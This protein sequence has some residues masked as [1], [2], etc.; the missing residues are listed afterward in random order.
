MMAILRIVWV[1]GGISFLVQAPALGQGQMV[2]S[3][4]AANCHSMRHLPFYQQ[5]CLRR[6]IHSRRDKESDNDR[7]VSQVPISGTW[8]SS[9]LTTKSQCDGGTNSLGSADPVPKKNSSICSTRN[10][11]ACGVQG[12][13]RYSFN[14]I[15]CRSTHSPHACFD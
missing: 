7:W 3:A 9:D 6:P 2:G 14:S 12:C 13:N 11:C 5:P 1:T 15:F 10:C 8:E 4:T